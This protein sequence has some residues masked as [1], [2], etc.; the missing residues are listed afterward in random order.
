M[1]AV[2]EPITLEGV[3]IRELGSAEWGRLKDVEGPF[4]GR[5]LSPTETARIIVAEVDGT[6]VGYWVA[7]A[8]IHLDPLWFNEA[9]RHHPKV[10][11]AMLGAMVHTL[12]EVGVTHAYAVIADGDQPVSGELAE[13]IGF[14]P[15]PGRLYGG[16]IP[17]KEP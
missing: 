10:G 2:L 9:Y 3:T 1:L 7:A 13:K 11:L 5:V 16:I 4:H 17:S 15:V 8:T 14:A 6:I 12:Q